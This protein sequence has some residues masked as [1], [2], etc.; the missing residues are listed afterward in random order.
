MRLPARHLR[1]GLLT[2][3]GTPL[4]LMLVTRPPGGAHVGNIDR[5]ATHDAYLPFQPDFPSRGGFSITLGGRTF[6]PVGESTNVED[7]DLVLTVPLVERDVFYSDSLTQSDGT[8]L[9]ARIVAR[10]ALPLTTGPGLQD[11][12]GSPAAS[13]VAFLEP[14]VRVHGGDTLTLSSGDAFMVVPPIQH[15]ALGDTVGLSWH[16]D[17]GGLT[18]D[19]DP[20]PDA[21][22]T[23][24]TD[25]SWWDR[26]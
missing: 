20:T 16:G 8:P 13:H 1:D 25:D 4:K 26:P 19:P 11:V 7:F 15:D 5:R 22:G 23:V 9:R 21:P 17:T 14:G 12:Q 18:P 10:G 6:V 3:P 24:P 2:P